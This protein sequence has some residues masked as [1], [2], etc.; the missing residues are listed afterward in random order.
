MVQFCYDTQTDG[1]LFVGFN[2]KQ[3]PSKKGSLGFICKI[4]FLILEKFAFGGFAVAVGFFI[5]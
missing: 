4:V 2:K 5:G 1:Y 3:L